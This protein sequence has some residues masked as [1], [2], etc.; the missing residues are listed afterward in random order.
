M[1]QPAR[2]GNGH[3]A[4]LLCERRVTLSCP[5]SSALE[6]E[7][8]ESNRALMSKSARLSGLEEQ[9]GRIRDAINKR[10]AYYESCS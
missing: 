8:Q 6:M 3:D 10:V 7:I 2:E 4:F 5:L 9:V 1:A